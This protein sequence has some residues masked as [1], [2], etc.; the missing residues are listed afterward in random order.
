[1]TA[2]HS[3]NMWSRRNHVAQ[4]SAVTGIVGFS[5]HSCLH[6]AHR[7]DGWFTRTVSLVLHHLLM[8]S[9]G[10]EWLR[11]CSYPNEP[12]RGSCGCTQL[13]KAGPSLTHLASLHYRMGCEPPWQR[14]KFGGH[15]GLVSGPCL[16]HEL[17]KELLRLAKA[18]NF[19]CK[20]AFLST[21]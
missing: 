13:S 17:A 1:M 15:H 5:F 3:R 11:V 9:P 16:L 6:Y 10:A 8:A 7:A 2:F 21:K 12:C 4:R 19:S 18:I 14:G 20:Q